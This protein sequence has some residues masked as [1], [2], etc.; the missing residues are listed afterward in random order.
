M[1]CSSF[2]GGLMFTLI[3]PVAGVAQGPAAVDT[4]RID[5]LVPPTSPPG[6]WWGSRS[7]SCGMAGWC[8]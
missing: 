6:T 5:S 4:A 8:S 2:A 3:L 1:R 7:A